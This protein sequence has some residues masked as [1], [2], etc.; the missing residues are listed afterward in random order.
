MD[1]YQ[2]ARNGVF[3][4]YV[5][6]MARG[7]EIGP[8]YR[9]TFPKSQGYQVTVIDHC[10]TGELRKKYEADGNVPG[11][12]VEQIESVDVVWTGGSY[13][14]TPGLPQEVDYVVAS[15]VIEHTVDLAGFLHD[16]S[17]L[18]KIGG[19][20]LL[21]IP[22]RSCVLDYYRPATT[23]G[24]V[25]LA[26]LD[27]MAYDIKSEM[28]ELWYGALYSGSGAWTKEHLNLCLSKGSHPESQYIANHSGIHWNNVCESYR[29][30][31]DLPNSYRDAHRWVLDPINFK[32]IVT[33]LAAYTGLGMR[34]ETMPGRFGCE[35]YAVLRKVDKGSQIDAD[36]IEWARLQSLTVKRPKTNL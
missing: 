25:L 9:P 14:K 12:L 26:H 4:L 16:C 24:D 27:P 22:E 29:K 17:S 21:A 31:Q 36:E 33:F 23:M 7:I 3:N 19:H 32:E 18:L 1:D 35:F 5:S 20:L 28:D 2:L 34:I 15:H 30:Q 11:Q 6:K 10:S 8:S 13:A